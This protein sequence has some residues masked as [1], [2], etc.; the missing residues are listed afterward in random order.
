MGKCFDEM[1]E[2]TTESVWRWNQRRLETLGLY[3]GDIDGDPGRLTAR[4]VRELL[5]GSR[6]PVSGSR[7]PVSG[8]Q[9]P[10]WCSG[11]ADDEGKLVVA[12]DP[13]H[14]MGNRRAGR[15][16][17]GAVARGVAGADL[18][19]AD[20]VLRWALDLGVMLERCGARVFLTRVDGHQSAP[21]RGR[22]PAARAAGADVL[23]SLHCNAYNGEA[24][25]TETFYRGAANRPLAKAVNGA[26]VEALGTRSRGVKIEEQSQHRRLAV[27]DF[28]QACLLEIGFL[29]HAGNRAKMMDTRLRLA[30]CEGLAG[31][32]LQEGKRER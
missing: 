9:D 22:V 30:A 27:L 14:G 15:Y 6:F 12:L 31:A 4:A 28:P 10:G 25:G 23:V 20:V 7:L 13:G 16:D 2:E 24:N 21:L 1:S 17:P 5:K 29:D 26:V 3:R 8:S 32:I 11:D 18:T 19:E